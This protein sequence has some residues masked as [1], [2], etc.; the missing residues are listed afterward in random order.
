MVPGQRGG[1]RRC[2]CSRMQAMVKDYG[3]AECH[4]GRDI[5]E[6]NPGDGYLGAVPGK[7]TNKY[8]S[9]EALERRPGREC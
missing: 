1:V 2:V 3:P 5:E 9:P 4:L 8:K 7:G 6:A